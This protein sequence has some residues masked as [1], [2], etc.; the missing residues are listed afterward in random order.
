MYKDANAKNVTLAYRSGYFPRRLKSDIAERL[1]DDA[2]KL[3]NELK[4]APGTVF[5]DKAVKSALKTK[6]NYLRDA[7]LQLMKKGYKFDA[8]LDAI[9]NRTRDQLFRKSAAEYSRRLEFPSSFYER[10][11]RKILPQYIDEI[12]LRMAEKEVF[13]TGRPWSNLMRN[14]AEKD[15]AE[16]RMVK[17][18]L[19]MWSGQYEVEHGLKGTQRK[20]ANAFFAYE[21]GGKIGL[22]TAT[23]P[24]LTQTLISS[25]PDLGAWNVIKGGLKFLTPEGRKFARQSGALNHSALL[26][27]GGVEPKG[28]WGKFSHRLTKYSGFQTVN[29]FNQYLAATSFN[30]AVKGWYRSAQGMNPHSRWAQKRLG[31][32]GIDYK[33]PLTEKAI[34]EGMYRF[35]TDSQLQ[36]NVLNDPLFFNNPKLRPFV[37][38]KRFGYRQ[39]VYIKDMLTREVKRGN[40]L[41]ILRLMIGG[42]IGGEAVIFAK[43]Q[44]KSMLSGEPAYRESDLNEWQRYLED[45]AAVG[46]FGVMSDIMAT[47]KISEMWS[48][49][50]FAVAPVIIADIE[51]IGKAVDVVLKDVE[52]YGTE[53]AIKR[54]ATA[55]IKQVGSLPR[56]AMRRLETDKQK[57]DRI[58]FLKGRKRGEI[59]DAMLQGD[60]DKAIKLLNL[61]N[62]N[63]TDYR[64]TYDDVNW[65]E[66]RKYA[67]RKAKARGEVV[68][69]Q[70]SKIQ[71]APYK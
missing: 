5:S 71:Q 46:S 54:N 43:N 32:F 11:I 31:D 25:L 8:A 13:G 12:S 7:V 3:L 2:T 10:D 42:V 40:V 14:I 47:D 55:P 65:S 61:W 21:T 53:T 24:N 57:V 16:S 48:G 50:K 36:R 58:K 66:V 26:T 37:L 20:F 38:F 29:R 52:K 39:A 51:N 69:M 62:D 64:F 41:P 23:I 15:F 44:I 70:L 34:S 49:A 17:D 56:Y 60:G 68:P 19:D 18:L 9:Q 27:F 35:A 1:F 45:I 28:F 63:Y 4:P 33:Q 59:L 22:G 6:S 67:E 30:S